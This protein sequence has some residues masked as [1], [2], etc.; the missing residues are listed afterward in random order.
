MVE[1]SWVAGNIMLDKEYYLGLP[2]VSPSVLCSSIMLQVLCFGLKCLGFEFENQF[3]H[4]VLAVIKM[5]KEF[6]VGVLLTSQSF[7]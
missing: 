7:S 6:P 2:P 3:V 4:K 1:Q 5:V